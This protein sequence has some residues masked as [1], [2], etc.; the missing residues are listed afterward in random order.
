[1][2]PLRALPGS[3]IYEA[4]RQHPVAL[5]R[6]E[7]IGL[8]S[9]SRMRTALSRSEIVRLLPNLYVAAEHAESWAARADAALAWAG[10]GAML[11][12]RSALFAWA[13]LNQ[14][15][16]VIDL[17]ICEDRKLRTPEWL[18]ARRAS[19]S[20]KPISKRGLPLAPVPFAIAQGYADMTESERTSAV[21]GAVAKDMTTPQGMRHAVAAMP[22]I[23]QRRSLESRITAAEKGAESWL[24]EHSLRSVFNTREFDQFIRQHEVVREGRLY[25]LDMYDPF[26][27]TCVELDSYAWHS[28]P[29]QRLRDIRRD[30]DV[31]ALG[32]LTVRLA[33]RDLTERPNWCRATV[34]SVLAARFST[35]DRQH[36]AN[37]Q[38]HP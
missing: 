14:P 18:K 7:L 24:E 23:R 36:L 9:D 20:I 35:S 30:A 29:D 37:S 2:R 4:L 25:R 32:I 17:L 1:M 38:N 33:S 8:S 28:S 19:Y 22:K 15:P 21:F 27:R 13:L 34:R 3:D 11:A 31:A 6:A 12:G 5:T 26:T 16:G 10:A